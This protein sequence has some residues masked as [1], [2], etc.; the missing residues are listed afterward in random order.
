MDAAKLVEC[1]AEDKQLETPIV[2]PPHLLGYNLS[3][4]VQDRLIRMIQNRCTA[5][6]GFVIKLKYIVDIRGGSLDH[7]TASVNFMVD[8][9][10]SCLRPEVNDQVNA[11]VSRVLKIGIFAE[12]G[13]LSIFVPVTHMSENYEFSSTTQPMFIAKDTNREIKQHSVINVRIEQIEMLDDNYLPTNTTSCV[14]KAMGTL[15][16]TT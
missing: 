1:Y 16:D 15:S 3:H 11:I 12:L 7:R 10:A 14:L 8:Y 4:V 2:V 9:V 5:A 6:E 13:P